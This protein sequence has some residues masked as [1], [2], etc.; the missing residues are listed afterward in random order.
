MVWVAVR[1]TGSCGGA[2]EGGGAAVGGAEEAGAEGRGVDW[3]RGE[4]SGSNSKSLSETVS[5]LESSMVIST[6]WRLEESGS[7]S[8]ERRLDG[9][10][11]VGAE[12]VAVPA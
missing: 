2:G 9:C 4:G 5:V 8:V 10:E 11:W 7:E 1:V 6:R 12:L 3:K